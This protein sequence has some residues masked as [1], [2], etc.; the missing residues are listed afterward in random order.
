MEIL[1][2]KPTIKDWLYEDRPREKLIL[3]GKSSLSNTELLAI[4][5]RSGTP[6]LSAVDLAKK[7]M[8]M[9][10]N[11]LHALSLLTTTDLMKIKGVGEAKAVSIVSAL[12]LGRRHKTADIEK[13]AKIVTS[14][15]AFG[16]I[17]PCLQDIKHEEFWIILLNRANRVI[18]THQVSQGGTSSTVADPKIIFKLAIDELASGLILAH[19]H[20][21][22][23]TSASQA[24][25]NLTDKIK[26]AGKLLDVQVLDH[27]IIAGQKYFS[28]AD[29]GIL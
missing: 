14:R 9:V 8:H 25:I 1:E 26:T 6:A 12:E 17:A 11:N 15:D 27:L 7:I 21:S 29:E 13:K 16:V 5:L 4:L 20:P 23:E 2:K 18:R 22:G 10:G 28:F 19:N 3:R 24:D